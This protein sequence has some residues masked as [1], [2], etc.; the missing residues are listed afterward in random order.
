MPPQDLS[1]LY[2]QSLNLFAAQI[3]T[4]SHSLH[5][6]PSQ[7]LTSPVL[8]LWPPTK[9][10]GNSLPPPV[11]PT[12]PSLLA[13]ELCPSSSGTQTNITPLLLFPI[14]GRKPASSREP[15]PSKK[16]GTSSSLGNSPWAGTWLPPQWHTKVLLLLCSELVCR[17]P[18]AQGYVCMCGSVSEIR[19]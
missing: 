3:P 15:S 18:P 5:I 10:P 9:S 1:L 16:E 7:T 19:H 11:S 12:C 14:L 6:H 8:P 4:P 2:P 13:R 17:C